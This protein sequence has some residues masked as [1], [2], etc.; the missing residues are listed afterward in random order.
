[1][2]DSDPF[3]TEAARVA[4]LR[5]LELLDTAAE[6]VFDT[7]TRLAC[8]AT[9]LPVALISLIDAER[10]WFKSA[11]GLPQAMQIG[12][13]GSPCAQAIGQRGVFELLKE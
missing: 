10:Q 1:M 4:R 7:F 2:Q 13:A 11:V 9:G 3:P 6:E 8:S 12:R 5:S